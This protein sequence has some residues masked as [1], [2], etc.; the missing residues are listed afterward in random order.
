MERKSIEYIGPRR[1]NPPVLEDRIYDDDKGRD[2]VE[3]VRWEFLTCEDMQVKHR[4]VAR[5]VHPVLVHKALRKD[6]PN[7]S[8]VYIKYDKNKEITVDDIRG[9]N[10]SKVDPNADIL[11]ENAQLREIVKEKD[12]E[13]LAAKQ[14][15][16]K[17]VENDERKAMEAVKL[18]DRGKDD[19]PK[20][21]KDA[22]KAKNKPKPVGA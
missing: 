11:E 3:R 16:G 22:E 21:A 10:A 13:I 15:G 20:S 2:V 19:V 12:K 18:E 8:P 17:I 6:M 5:G 4:V 14:A 7:S 9:K 1:D